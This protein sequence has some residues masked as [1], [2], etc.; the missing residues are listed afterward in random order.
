MLSTT[1]LILELVLLKKQQEKSK[2]IL[3]TSCFNTEW[4]VKGNCTDSLVKKTKIVP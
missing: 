4:M 2:I 1:S 3:S